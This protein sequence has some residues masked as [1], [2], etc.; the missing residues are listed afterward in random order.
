MLTN[1]EI[2]VKY[3]NDVLNDTI[4]NCDLIKKQA[5]I[6]LE[7]IKPDEDNLYYYNP[8]PVDERVNFIQSFYLTETEYENQFLTILQPFQI[9]WLAGV[10]GIYNKKNNTRKHRV[11][12]CEI[13]RGNAK[14]QIL[15][16]LDLFDLTFG[17]DAQVIYA[18]NTNKNTME[19]GFAKIVKLI[20]QIDP[21]G[22]KNKRKYFKVLYNKIIYKNNRLI[23]SS[24]ESE[25]IDGL[26]GSLMC[27]DEVHLFNRPNVL[28]AMK[29]SMV[30][31]PNSI[32]FL[33]TTAGA[34]INS[35]CYRMRDYSINVLNGFYNDP[36][37]FTLIYTVNPDQI[38][39]IGT[40]E[41]P[42]DDL[43]F[44]QMANPN[45]GISVETDVIQNELLKS[46]Q[47]PI[48]K[49]SIYQ[50]HLNIW[51]KNNNEKPYIEEKYVDAAMQ[52]ISMDDPMFNGL[53]CYCGVDLA[54]N[55]DISAVVYMFIIENKY[56]FFPEYYLCE[57]NNNSSI[58][59]DY[60]KQ[61]AQFGHINLTAGNVTDYDRILSDIL[62]VYEKHEIL[63]LFID[64][65]NAIQFAINVQEAGIKVTKYS[66][67]GGS[68]NLPLKEL[69]R[70]MLNS[71]VVLQKN[72]ITKWMFENAIIGTD[73]M[74]NYFI[75]KSNKNYKVDGISAM[76]DA[77]GGYLNTPHSGFNVW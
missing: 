20:D 4:P 39:D 45:L 57:D 71:N 30:K 18:G 41:N 35:E 27:A 5:A 75:K 51:L 34:D 49:A 47:N 77:L 48:E 62:K 13:G 67:L 19:N 1:L 24:N 50:K 3:C 15:C 70:L 63:E 60:L 73:K 29:S 44:I 10:F 38:K 61:A 32:L 74:G 64:K 22:I 23:T 42:A 65:F 6:F 28:Q 26:S 14:T 58:T 37:L 17:N 9:F 68:T 40:S 11:V 69:E 59:K 31:R 12:Y 56:Y 46:K 55:R 2:A 72:T 7:L 52:K 76:I 54:E 33:I 43:K 8:T 25:A 66:Q 36:S 21:K 16:L 53:E